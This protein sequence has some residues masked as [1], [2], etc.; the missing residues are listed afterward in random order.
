[1]QLQGHEY[2]SLKIDVQ[3]RLRQTELSVEKTDV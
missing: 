1:M 2:E 3:V